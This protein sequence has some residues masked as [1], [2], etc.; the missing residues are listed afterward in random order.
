MESNIEAPQ[1]ESSHAK[2]LRLEKEFSEFMKS[3]LGWEKTINRKQMRS[4]WNAAGTNVDIIAERPNEKGE[5]FKRVSRAY[6]WLCITPILYGVYESYY[7]DSEIG[8][9]I[10]YLGI[11]IEF[12]ALGSK[13]YGDRLNKENAWVECKSLKGKATVKQ[14]QIMIAERNAYLASGDSEYKIVE[15]YF[16]SENGFVETALQYAHDMNIFCYQK[17][18]I[19]FEYITNWT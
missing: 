14:L 3:D 17:T 9:P 8:L 2:G 16:V 12:L 6:L 11:F 1:A 15:T 7:G 4:H 10:F 13:I 5:R 19:G 18:D